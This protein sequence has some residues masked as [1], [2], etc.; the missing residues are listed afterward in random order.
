MELVRLR[1]EPPLD[2]AL[3]VIRAGVL[4][5]RSDDDLVDKAQENYDDYGSWGL[6]ALVVEPEDVVRVWERDPASVPLPP[7]EPL[8]SRAGTSSRVCT[9]GHGRIA[10]SRHC[11]SRSERR[12][13]PTAARGVRPGPAPAARAVAALTATPHTGQR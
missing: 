3:V 7:R 2:D 13:V 10:S 5:D 8:D 4:E 12:D 9:P 6:S 1:G 11:S